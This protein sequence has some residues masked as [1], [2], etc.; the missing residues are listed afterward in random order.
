MTT[1][2]NAGGILATGTAPAD[3]S[4][5]PVTP[6]TPVTTETPAAPA[7]QVETA[8]KPESSSIL[9]P[10][11]A[12]VLTSEM[13]QKLSK[14]D[15]KVA[16]Y[17]DKFKTVDD[18]VKSSRELE[19]KFHKTRAIPEL[20]KDATPEQVKEYRESV[21]IPESWDKYDT[22]LDGVTIGENDKPIVDEF[23]KRAHDKNLKPSEVK[24][25]LQ[26]YFEVATQR[27]KEVIQNAERQKLEVTKQLQKE[28]AHNFEHNKNMVTN[29]LQKELGDDNF[30]KLINATA[31]DGSPLINN[32]KLLNYF[33]E[34]AKNSGQ[35][36]TLLPNTSD[37]VSLNTRSKE[38][39]KLMIENPQAYYNNPK[40]SEEYKQI[41]DAMKKMQN[42]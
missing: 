11:E 20:A 35:A 13:K 5:T 38:I 15:E 7:V 17:L 19:S 32:T 30:N 25:S 37:P 21:G 1:N 6:V 34:V 3:N 9:Q 42:S 33:L 10:E 23:L 28:W 40:I 36:H 31:Q 4:T 8:P 24:A 26:A 39:E 2:E 27:N 18:L 41:K 12:A 14:G 22:N 16:K 29:H